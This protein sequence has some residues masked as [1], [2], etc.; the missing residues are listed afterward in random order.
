VG[1]DTQQSIL[2]YINDLLTLDAD[3]QALCGGDVRLFP[4]WATPDA[5][6]PYLVHRMD[7]RASGDVYPMRQAALIVDAWSYSP[8]AEEVT[9]IR[10]RVLALLDHLDF[11]TD[12]VSHCRVDLQTDG[13]VPEEAQGIWHY[14]MQFDCRLYRRSEV[15]SI[16][17]R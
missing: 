1:I 5:E 11:S 14:T 3:M 4:V 7:M 13:F 10:Q 15:D 9:N 2:T 17:A 12:E 6:M 16:L 8:N